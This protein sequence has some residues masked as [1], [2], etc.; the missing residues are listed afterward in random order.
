MLDALFEFDE[1]GILRA[2]QVPPIL[3]WMS[4]THI[5]LL[6]AVYL[7]GEEGMSRGRTRRFEE[8]RADAMRALELRDYLHWERNRFG[9]LAFLCLTWK[10]QDAARLLVKVARNE[11]R[12]STGTSGMKS[13]TCSS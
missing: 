9:R 7:C 1:L 11:L 2:T 6:I 10:G 13:P 8:V 5:D 4:A 12:E 3:E